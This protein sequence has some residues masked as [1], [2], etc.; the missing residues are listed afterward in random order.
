M[1]LGLALSQSC[2]WQ[3][4]L[5]SGL[6]LMSLEST[7]SAANKLFTSE[8]VHDLYITEKYE[9]RHTLMSTSGTSYYRGTHEECLT[10]KDELLNWAY[11]KTGDE[12]FLNLMET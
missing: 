2:R 4:R 11:D 7:K 12:G 8:G 9:H 1:M 6:N 10:R 3:F 5:K